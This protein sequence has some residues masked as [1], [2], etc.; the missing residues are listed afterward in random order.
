MLP[1]RRGDYARECSIN[2]VTIPTTRCCSVSWR[3]STPPTYQR[4][5][6]EYFCAGLDR[7]LAQIT[8]LRLTVSDSIDVRGIHYVMGDKALR[9][10]CDCNEH[11]ML[12]A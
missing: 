3:T 10:A 5:N 2:H 7:L 12:Q 4:W 6:N 1:Q 9:V 11:L 8:L